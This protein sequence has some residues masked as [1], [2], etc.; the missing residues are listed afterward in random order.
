VISDRHLDAAEVDEPIAL[1]ERSV[2]EDVEWT[3]LC[4]LNNL[5]LE[6][7][8]PRLARAAKQSAVPNVTSGRRRHRA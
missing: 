1:Q 4:T 8:K 5:L 2:S 7:Q 6:S 3:A